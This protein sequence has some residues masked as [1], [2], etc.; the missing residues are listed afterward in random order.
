MVNSKKNTVFTENILVEAH[1]HCFNNKKE[2]LDS[3][4]CGCFHCLS[5]YSPDKIDGWLKEND[6]DNDYG[7][8]ALCSCGVDALI[9]SA[10]NFPITIEF[11]QDMH[12]RW[13][14]IE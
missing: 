2:I 5:I 3:D 14:G 8:T 9:G 12:E 11:M 1:K 4:S 7:F 10:S 13:F 6:V